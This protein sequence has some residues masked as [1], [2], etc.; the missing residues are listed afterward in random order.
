MQNMKYMMGM[1]IL[2]EFGKMLSKLEWEDDRL[3]K[4]IVS[5]RFEDK[6]LKWIPYYTWANDSMDKKCY[7]LIKLNSSILEINESKFCNIRIKEC[8]TCFIFY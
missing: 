3:Y 8:K 7:R 5:N 1:L 4:A 2:A 6:K